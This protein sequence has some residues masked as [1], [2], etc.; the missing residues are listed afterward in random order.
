[1]KARE[2]EQARVSLRRLE[3][4]LDAQAVAAERG[5]ANGVESDALAVVLE[6]IQE[7]R[8]HLLPSRPLDANALQERGYS[9]DE[10]YALLRVHGVKLSTGGR[11]RISAAVLGRIE[12]GEV[13]A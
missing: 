1:M 6:A 11:I 4:H 2:I 12:R 9:R 10:S 13:P 8:G 7:L 3:E 5:R